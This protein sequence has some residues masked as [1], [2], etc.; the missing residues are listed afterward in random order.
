MIMK[1]EVMEM[2]LVHISFRHEARSKR[3]GALNMGPKNYVFGP[4]ST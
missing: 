3:T 1:L 4:F 2:F